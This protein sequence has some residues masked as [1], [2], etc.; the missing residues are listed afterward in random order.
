[1]IVTAVVF[2]AANGRISEVTAALM[3][4]AEDAV[5]MTISLAGI[6]CFWTGIMS[7]AKGSGVTDIIAGALKPIIKFLFPK[8]RDREAEDAV[9]MNI[10]ANMLGMSN[11]ATPLGIKAVERL[12]KLS[13]GK[14]ATDDMCMFVVINTA[15]VQ[16]IPSTVIAMRQAAGSA[17]PAEIILPVWI[18]SIAALS[19]GVLCAKI[20]AAVR[21]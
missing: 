1:M 11:A 6:M 20:F 16:L 14:T 4:G 7:V 18:C 13:G 3:S 19:V 2:G 12:S 17:A 10:T 21:L 5:S 15:S 9:V 8:L